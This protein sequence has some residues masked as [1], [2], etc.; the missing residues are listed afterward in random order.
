MNL[1]ECFLGSEV[2]RNSLSGAC[3]IPLCTLALIGAICILAIFILSL[4]G[5]QND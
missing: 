2:C 4:R 1:V 3:G 5:K